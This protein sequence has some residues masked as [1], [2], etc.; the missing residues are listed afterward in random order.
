MKYNEKMDLV[1]KDAMLIK[2]FMQN[3]KSV[4]AK[5]LNKEYL[6]PKTNKSEVFSF[7]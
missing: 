3:P 4:N 1:K 6:K 5:S 2:K 7:M